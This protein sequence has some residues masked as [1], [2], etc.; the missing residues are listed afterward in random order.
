MQ[1]NQYFINGD[2]KGAIAYMCDHKEFQDVL[3]DYIAIFENCE[4]RTY[5]VPECQSL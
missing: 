5:D 4:Y 3:P 2:I 1:L